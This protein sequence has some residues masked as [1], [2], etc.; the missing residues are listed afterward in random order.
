MDIPIIYSGLRPGEKLYEEKLM[1]SE[2]LERTPNELI[3]VAHPLDFDRD[4]LIEQAREL[5]LAAEKND[6]KNIRDLIRKVVPTYTQ[7]DNRK[8]A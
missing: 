8:G 6:E 7:I 2:G 3:H 4:T 1:D 5:F